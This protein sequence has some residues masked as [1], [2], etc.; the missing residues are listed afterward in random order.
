MLARFAAETSGER[1]EPFCTR[2]HLPSRTPDNMLL[3][4]LKISANLR[5]SAP[6]AAWARGFVAGMRIPPIMTGRREHCE[7]EAPSSAKM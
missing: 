7:G 6:R 1:L 5:T 2:K 4:L 3:D